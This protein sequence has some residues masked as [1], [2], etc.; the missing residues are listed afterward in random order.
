MKELIVKY[1]ASNGFADIGIETNI[2]IVK[3]ESGVISIYTEKPRFW[4]VMK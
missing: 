3:T 2:I 4:K 1:S